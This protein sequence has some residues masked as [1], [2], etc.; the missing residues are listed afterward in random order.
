LFPRILLK[1]T[2]TVLGFVFFLIATVSL[3]S[4]LEAQ[5]LKEKRTELTGTTPAQWRVIWTKNP[6]T[7]AT[8]AWSTAEKAPNSGIFIGPKSTGGNP[9]D[10]PNSVKAQ[11]NGKYS[12]DQELYYHH[13][14]LKD[15][16]PS[17][18]YYFMMASG[19]E[20]SPELHFRTAPENEQKFKLISGGDSRSDPDKRREMNVVIRKLVQ[21]YPELL[22]LAHGGDYVEDGTD[23]DQ[24]ST[25]MSDHELTTTKTGRV[26][27]IIPARGNHEGQG[28][29]YNEVFDTPGGKENYYHTFLTPGFLL[30]TLNTT[31]ST[32]GNQRTYLENTLKKHRNKR[33]KVAQYHRPAYPGVKGPGGTKEDWVPLFEQYGLHL[34]LEN[35]GHVYKRTPPILNGEP[36][37]SGVVYM[38]EGGMGVPQRTPKKDRWYLQSPGTTKATHHV[39]LL[40]V[41][42]ENIRFSTID[43]RLNTVERGSIPKTAGN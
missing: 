24:F 10:Y 15:L 22:A 25:W 26:L 29:L 9:Q 27:P 41:G 8:I 1:R 23:L 16:K 4:S 7:Q 13:V 38:G 19:N 6:Q 21:K 36:D 32:A 3:H 14:R 28:P 40:H 37:P 34:A 31:I 18:T 20:T 2:L 17:T 5:D 39:I 11:N 43:D 35:D 12:G 42:P 30:L 33:W